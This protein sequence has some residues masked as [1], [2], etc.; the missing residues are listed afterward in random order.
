MPIKSSI[1]PAASQS[2]STLIETLVALLILAIGLLSVQSM[3]M[4][5][6]RTN[7]SA[8]LRTEAQLLV[9]DMTNRILAYE[10]I[11]SVADNDDYD[12]IDTDAAAA[13]PGC[14]AAGC[15]QGQQINLDTF[16]WKTE[17]EARLPGGRGTVNFDA[18]AYALTVMWDNDKTGANGTGCSGDSDVDLTCYTIPLNL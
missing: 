3:Q 7:T 10:D 8:Y 9:E 2:G 15:N 17:I 18:G 12:G 11:A 16:E 1:A 13:D 6:L 5:S 4:V 14:T